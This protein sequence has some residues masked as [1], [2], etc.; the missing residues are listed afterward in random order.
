VAQL[1]LG[2]ALRPGGRVQTG[3]F[4]RQSLPVFVVHDVEQRAQPGFRA[5]EG[6]TGR[7]RPLDAAGRAAHDHRREIEDRRRRVG[8]RGHE[9]RSGASA[10]ARVW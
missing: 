8:G 2:A 6:R 1:E 4:L 5:D 10:R 7:A 3:E 9:Q